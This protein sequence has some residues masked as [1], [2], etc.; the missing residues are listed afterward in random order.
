[1]KEL[2]QAL[3]LFFANF[4]Q[5]NERDLST[6]ALSKFLFG[7]N[8]E[9][10]QKTALISVKSRRTL[11]FFTKS[12]SLGIIV[13]LPGVLASCGKMQGAQQEV[14]LRYVK[15]EKATTQSPVKD[16]HFSGKVKENREVNLSFRVGGPLAQLKVKEGDYVNKGQVIA[17]IDS[18]DY[19]IKL[20][21]AEAQF[22]QTKGEYERHKELFNRKKLPANT[23]DRIE[24]GYLMAQSNLKATRNAL[25]DTKL[26]APF[27]GY[28]HKKM[29]ENFETVAPGRPI[30]SLIDMG[31]LEV[32]VSIPESQLNLVNQVS[33]AS[34]DVKTAN[35][36]D[37][38][39]ELSSIGEKSNKDN[40]FEVRFLFDP[41]NA[42]DVRPGMNAEV[43]LG[44]N[45]EDGNKVFV[46]VE[47]VFYKK[48]SPAVWVYQP[49]TSSVSLKNVK[50]GQITEGGKMSIT[51][52]IKDGDWVVTAGVHSLVS[53]QKVNLLKKHSKTNIGGEL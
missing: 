22:K 29:V 34:C 33:K 45:N 38:P 51:S 11:P 15:A 6:V 17:E 52:G 14:G 32:T 49:S 9:I 36:L 13:L 18:R 39:L 43:T 21:A 47:S 8:R 30:V 3:N 46:P 27:S 48:N 20:Q 37:I 4:T 16:F 44:V 10:E 31:K 1:M 42:P 35:N 23:F 41:Q 28:V 2:K 40:L 50:V 26:A 53:N 19:E 24:A 5:G 25:N 12:L 7:S